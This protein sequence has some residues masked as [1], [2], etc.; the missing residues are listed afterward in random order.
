MASNSGQ[1]ERQI[2]A[3]E[4]EIMK[5][6]KAD[7]ELAH[8]FAILVAIAGVSTI[9]AFALLIDMPEL[10]SLNSGR[11]QRLARARPNARLSGTW[12]GRTFI[13]GGQANV[14]RA[15][16]MP[17]LVANRFNRDLKTKYDQF[18]TAGKASKWPLRPS[19]ER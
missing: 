3:I 4:A 17:A 12:T 19:C 8:R 18:K 16:Y 15:L 7:P 2:S 14:R 9:T 5:H 1:I 13:R 6:I 10:A 11:Q